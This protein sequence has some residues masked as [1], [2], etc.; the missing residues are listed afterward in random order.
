[1]IYPD[2]YVQIRDRFKDVIISGGENISSITVEAGVAKHPAISLCAVVRH[3]PQQP[4]DHGLAECKTG[5]TTV[6]ERVPAAQKV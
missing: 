5:E 4:G 1:M 2:S 3:L 6:H